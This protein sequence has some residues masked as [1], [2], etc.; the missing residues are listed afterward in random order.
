MARTV[1]ELN[2][3]I[4]RLSKE[5]RSARKELRAFGSDAEDAAEDVDKV[6]RNFKDSKEQLEGFGASLRA[7]GGDI[8]PLEDMAT[9]LEKLGPAGFAAAAGVA[10]L[11]AGAMAVA[12]M[13]ECSPG[14]N[15]RYS[16]RLA[17][18]LRWSRYRAAWP[19]WPSQ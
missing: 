4:K 15:C 19:R 13:G 1:E 17:C 9:A 7:V 18:R 10:A 5:I 14:N 8:G 6:G 16:S 12:K 11:V 3:D 2:A